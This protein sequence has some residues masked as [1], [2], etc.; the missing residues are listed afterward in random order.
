M[1]GDLMLMLNFHNNRTLTQM[2]L[3]Y[4]AKLKQTQVLSTNSLIMPRHTGVSDL[5]GVVI[6]LMMLHRFR[7]TDLRVRLVHA[8]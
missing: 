8:K 2:Y 1:S 3:V 7:M 4:S 5:D 6:T